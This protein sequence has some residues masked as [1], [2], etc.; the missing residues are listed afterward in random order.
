MS[1]VAHALAGD[2]ELPG[3][4]GVYFVHQEWRF[5]EVGKLDLLGIEPSR[6]RL[7]VLELKSGDAWAQAE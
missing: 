1:L 5:P 7:V 6:S 4:P 3:F 2:L